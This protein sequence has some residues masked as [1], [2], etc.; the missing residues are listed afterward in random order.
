[1]RDDVDANLTA[2]L[3]GAEEEIMRLREK[4]RDTDSQLKVCSPFTKP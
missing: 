3:A 1:M 2:E 4:L